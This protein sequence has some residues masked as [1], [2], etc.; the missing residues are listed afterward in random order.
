MRLSIKTGV[1]THAWDFE[2]PGCQGPGT[3][4]AIHAPKNRFPTLRP[5]TPFWR[6]RWKKC[7]RPPPG[8]QKGTFFRPLGYPLNYIPRANK[9]VKNIG[10][11]GEKHPRNGTGIPFL[12]AAFPPVPAGRPGAERAG[13][14][15]PPR[16]EGCHNDLRRSSQPWLVPSTA[17]PSTLP[18]TLTWW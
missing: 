14:D 4:E 3:T 9:Q 11:N 17:V 10:L 18:S 16:P 15:R 12:G 13:A 6:Q 7:L 5:R 2:F 8:F 1:L